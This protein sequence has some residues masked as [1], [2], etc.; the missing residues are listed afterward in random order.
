MLVRPSSFLATTGC[1]S[2]FSDVFVLEEDRDLDE[3]ERDLEELDREEL[4]REERDLEELDPEE[5]R[6]LGASSFGGASDGVTLAAPPN[7]P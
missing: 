1:R 2:V 6:G 4:D 5:D 7:S 3:D